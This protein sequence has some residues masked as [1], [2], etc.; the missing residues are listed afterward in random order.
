MT[1][2]RSFEIAVDKRI[3]VI[4]A[5]LEKD[6]TDSVRFERLEF[7]ALSISFY[8]ERKESLIDI[9]SRIFEK[10][11][12]E[13]HEGESVARYEVS[14]VTNINDDE[15]YNR[16]ILKFTCDI[17]HLQYERIA[18]FYLARLGI[19]FKTPWADEI[20]KKLDEIRTAIEKEQGGHWGLTD[21]KIDEQTG[22]QFRSL[23]L[24]P[25][26]PE[27]A[28]TGFEEQPDVGYDA[29]KGFDIAA[30]FEVPV[31]WDV[32][33]SVS[34]RCLDGY[35]PGFVEKEPINKN[36]PA[37]I[38]YRIW[39][40]DLGELGTV[41]ITKLRPGLS[42]IL[43]SGVPAN[44]ADK[45]PMWKKHQPEWDKKINEV[46]GDDQLG[47]ERMRKY[48]AVSKQRDKAKAEVQAR[49]KNH[50]A[51]VIKAY[52]NRL[53]DEVGIWKPNF[54]PPYLL[55]ISGYESVEEAYKRGTYFGDFIQASW[56]AAR[57]VQ[58][59]AQ[60]PEE[61]A[62]P[63]KP[64]QPDRGSGIDVWLDWYHA[65]NNAGYKITFKRLAA[66]SGYSANTFKQA[67]QRYKLERGI[68]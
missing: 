26:A 14:R 4:L 55:M 39:Q 59:K 8:S 31:D 16:S 65:M 37:S 61:V 22:Q 49:L 43:V 12:N 19:A 33:T 6:I 66:E 34:D 30:S 52:F 58:L 51:D 68:H 18:Y 46:L 28:A 63:D 32:L 40:E 38:T 48:L 27:P 50:Q 11:T 56:E 24:I 15:S 36:S 57:V 35:A 5:W 45:S 13:L 53:V 44:A 9:R 67:H 25:D 7:G 29:I 2:K 47:D 62:K 20:N 41:E 23:A 64:E 60:T 42:K 3:D 54:P 10:S 1:L 17:D 21:W